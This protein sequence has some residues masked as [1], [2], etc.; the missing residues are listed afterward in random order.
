LQALAVACGYRFTT[1]EAPMTEQDSF[2]W[3]EAP[4]AMLHRLLLLALLMAPPGVLGW[5]MVV[6]HAPAAAPGLA[7]FAPVNGS[8]NRLVAASLSENPAQTGADAVA[9][10]DTQSRDGVAVPSLHEGGPLL[11]RAH[12]RLG[13]AYDAYGGYPQRM[14][15]G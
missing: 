1:Q 15:Q 6:Q 3:L 9:L 7:E 2:D 4:P 5:L 14:P 8:G 10:D 12:G 11:S 13:K